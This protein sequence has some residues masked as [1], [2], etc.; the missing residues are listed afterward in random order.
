MKRV[1]VQTTVFSFRYSGNFL[2]DC[3][4]FDTLDLV[5]C[6][7]TKENGAVSVVLEV[8]SSR[9]E[10]EVRKC[11]DVWN[12]RNPQRHVDVQEVKIGEA[13]RQKQDVGSNVAELQA[14]RTDLEMTKRAL[15]TVQAQLVEAR[16]NARENLEALVQLRSL[17]VAIF[18]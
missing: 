1:R 11:V 5:K 8:A 3:A 10:C 18:R 6:E 16:M 2:L 4:V 13:K 17:G 15:S 7:Q 14:C 12:K 9:T